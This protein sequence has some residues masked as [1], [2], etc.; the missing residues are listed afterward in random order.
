MGNRRYLDDKSAA[1][2]I[3]FLPS[4]LSRFDLIFIVRDVREMDRDQKLAKHI[5]GVF[6]NAE[7]DAGT[8]RFMY[9]PKINE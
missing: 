3:N 4:I 2:N 5:M 1:E 8:F 6:M 7:T 9:V